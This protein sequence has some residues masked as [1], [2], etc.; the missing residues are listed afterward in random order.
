MDK[1]GYPKFLNLKYFTAISMFAYGYYFFIHLR[2]NPEHKYR[3][4]ATRRISR[5]TGYLT[6]MPLPPYLRVGI[7]KAFGGVYGVNYDDI[8]V[9][10]LNSFRTFN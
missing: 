6:S 3:M 7:Y 10:N 4:S 1:Y 5:M 2:A 9:E 8:L